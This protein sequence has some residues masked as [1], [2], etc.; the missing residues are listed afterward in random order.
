VTGGNGDLPPGLGVDDDDAAGSDQNQVDRGAS[1]TWPLAVG[2]ERV[3]ERLEFDEGAREAVLIGAG[4]GE[5]AGHLSGDGCQAGV[6]IREPALTLGLKYGLGR[7]HSGFPPMR[8]DAAP[9]RGVFF[10]VSGV[11]WWG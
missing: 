4:C 9:R 3:T 8:D 11:I 6:F 5:A 7:C 2:E 1:R 10:S